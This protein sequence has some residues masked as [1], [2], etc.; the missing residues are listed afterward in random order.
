QLHVR[1]G[2]Q[3]TWAIDGVV[4][5]NTNIASNVGPQFDP[6]DVDY[7]E[8]QRGGLS[9]EYG[10]RSF[11]RVNIA[12]R[13]GFEPSR[14][15]DLVSSYGRFNGEDKEVRFGDH[16]DRSADYV[17]VNGN[18]TD[19]GLS[20][21]DSSV[22]HDLGSGGGIFTSLIFNRTPNDQLRF[23][24]AARADF[25]QVPNTADDEAAGIRDRQREQDIFGNFSWLHTI[26]PGLVLQLAP[27]YHFNRAAFDGMGDPDNRVV[28]T[29][30]RASSYIGGQ[31][32]LTAVKG[33]HNAKIGF[34]GFAQRD[35]TLFGL[36]GANESGDL[37][38]FNQPR[39]VV[40]GDLEAI[41]LEDQ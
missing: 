15:V 12:T 7:V 4:V 37:V 17:S 14:Q 27:S 3:V 11:G 40:N 30:N 1:G 35:S 18:R 29:N 32:S 39:Q 21:P 38:N 24:G 8:E 19:H 16:N 41:F 22:I 20:T 9:A 31:V 28:T 23:V 5:P 25:Y 36:T 13:T 26:G 2:H 10:D 34:Y 6:K 33:R